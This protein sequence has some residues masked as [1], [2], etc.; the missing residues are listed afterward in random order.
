MP[1]D[2]VSNSRRHRSSLA[3]NLSS[4]LLRLMNWP[5][6]LPIADSVASCS[7]SR[8]RTAQLKNS[9]IPRAS[10][11]SRIGKITPPRSPARDAAEPRKNSGSVVASTIQ[12]GFALRQTCPSR[13]SPTAKI[14]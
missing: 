13:P 1:T 4:A 7:S 11:S 14:R 10:V 12:I 2:V 8:S 5:I 9:T 3:R 6:W